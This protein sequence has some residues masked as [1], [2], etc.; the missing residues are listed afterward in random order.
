MVK[1]RVDAVENKDGQWVEV[2]GINMC[3]NHNLMSR[4]GLT[5]VRP[6]LE[7]YLAIQLDCIVDNG[8]MT[9]IQSKGRIKMNIYDNGIRQ[10][11]V[12]RVE[13]PIIVMRLSTVENNG[14]GVRVSRENFV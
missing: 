12:L 2:P 1:T 10:L 9:A 13:H 7:E 5:N 6:E 11:E 3:F 8:Y 14:L 4:V